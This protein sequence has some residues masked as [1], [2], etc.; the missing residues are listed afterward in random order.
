MYVYVLED[1]FSSF[2]VDKMQ[3]NYLKHN[4]CISVPQSV[5]C[6]F[7]YFANMDMCDNVVLANIIILPF[8]SRS[9][10]RG[11]SKLFV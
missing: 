11:K 2:L 5:I 6:L 7:I 9:H 8:I 10:S 4:F 3:L 1:M